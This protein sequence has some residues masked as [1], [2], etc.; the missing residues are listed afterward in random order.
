MP[1]FGAAVRDYSTSPHRAE[2]PLGFAAFHSRYVKNSIAASRWLSH[3][4][5]CGRCPFRA[6]F[7]GNR[8]LDD[9]ALEEVRIV[10]RVQHGGVG[11]RELAKI[12]FGDESL[13]NHL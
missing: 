1:H 7:I 3:L 8:L 6:Q 10:A 12:L 9:H 5:S 2:Q 13:L 11:E 4:Y